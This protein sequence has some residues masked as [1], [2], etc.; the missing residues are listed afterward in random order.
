M[1]EPRLI[2]L[3]PTPYCNINCSYCYLGH[4]DD[5]RLMSN[6]VIEAVREKI[7]LRLP[8]DSAPSVVWHAGEPTTAPIRWYEHA[9]DRLKSASPPHASFA[10]QTNGIGLNRKWIDLFSRTNTNGHLELFAGL[11]F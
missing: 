11:A 9:Y 3:Q 5:R 6:D 2:V 8:S 7:F 10:V 1:I 4:R